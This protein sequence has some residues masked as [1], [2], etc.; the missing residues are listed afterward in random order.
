MYN[1]SF[2]NTAFNPKKTSF[3][4]PSYSLLL[5]IS[6]ETLEMFPV[7]SVFIYTFSTYYFLFVL[8]GILEYV[9]FYYSLPHDSF[10]LK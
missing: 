5:Q 9:V 6:L 8:F 7:L 1:S 4:I 3:F 2:Q 10:H